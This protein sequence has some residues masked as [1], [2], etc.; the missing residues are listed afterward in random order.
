MK[1]NKAAVQELA[2]RELESRKR[3]TELKSEPLI[4]PELI[5]G[6]AGAISDAS[7]K[8][9]IESAVSSI[10]ELNDS[11]RAQSKAIEKAAKDQ[12]KAISDSA[13]AQAERFAGLERSIVDMV[14]ALQ[15]SNELSY[16]AIQKSNNDLAKAIDSL[17]PVDYTMD[18]KRAGAFISSVD[19]KAKT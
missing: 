4:K 16:S 1:A 6:I 8:S 3:V 7:M 12:A 17:K 13:K 18:I 11:I 19:L 5:E 15:V 14:N 9:E 2:R 10:N